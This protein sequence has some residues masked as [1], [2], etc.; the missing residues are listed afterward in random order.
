MCYN[1]EEIIGIIGANMINESDNDELQKS[2]GLKI[3]EKIELVK[4]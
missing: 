2:R 1:I 3:E 4:E